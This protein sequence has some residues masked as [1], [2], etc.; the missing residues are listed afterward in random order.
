[1]VSLQGSSPRMRGTLALRG[2]LCKLFGIIPAYA[3][4]T[5]VWMDTAAGFWDHPR[6][7]GEHSWRPPMDLNFSGSSP[8]MRGTHQTHPVRHQH[9]GIIP[10]YAGNT[11]ARIRF[12]RKNWDHPRVCGEHAMKLIFSSWVRGSSPRMRGTLS[13]F[14]SALP[15]AGIIPAYAGNTSSVVRV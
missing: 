2:G 4:N 1:M 9:R 8:R 6:V 14:E 15:M 7:C 10:A 13:L 5:T 11:N 3:G 12:A